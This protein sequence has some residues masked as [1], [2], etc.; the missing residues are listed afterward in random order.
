MYKDMCF[1][2]VS[3]C[4]EKAGIGGNPKGHKLMTEE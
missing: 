3:L 4:F 1:L 2:G